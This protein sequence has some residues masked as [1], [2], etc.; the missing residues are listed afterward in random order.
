MARPAE[1]DRHAALASATKVFWRQGY[2][3]TSVSQL[4][5]AME[6]SASSL[7]AVFGDKR[8]LFIEVLE[9]FADKTEHYFSP[10]R[11]IDDPCELVETF[12]HLS[13]SL[14]QRQLECGCMMVNTMLELSG[15]DD[16][17][18][19]LAAKK[20]HQ[21]QSLLTDGFLRAQKAGN[22]SDSYSAK[23]LAMLVMNLSQGLRVSARVSNKKEINEVIVTAL[24]LIG[25]N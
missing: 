5:G 14:P 6:L 9:N 15:V 21:L 4:L 17:L 22:L 25:S 18:A 20:L 10:L 1:Y 24:T 2:S 19:K 8:A 11:D 23:S 12:F 16:D 3:A 7:Y 13:F